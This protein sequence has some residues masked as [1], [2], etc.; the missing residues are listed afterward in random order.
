[1]TGDRPRALDA[2][3]YV[4]VGGPADGMRIDLVHRS[5]PDLMKTTPGPPDEVHFTIAEEP[6]YVWYPRNEVLAP[7]DWIYRRV[8]DHPG[9][10]AFVLHDPGT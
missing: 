9:G 7:A 10:P 1:M 3:P 6:R 4:F 2:T 8:D 5:S